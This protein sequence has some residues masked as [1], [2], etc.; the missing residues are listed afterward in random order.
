MTYGSAGGNGVGVGIGIGVGVG[1]GAGAAQAAMKGSA[2]SI[3]TRQIPP[4]SVSN[5]VLFN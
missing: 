1:T 4:K 5:F 2:A 3:S